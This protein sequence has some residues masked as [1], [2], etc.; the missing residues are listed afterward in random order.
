M[1]QAI[2]YRYARCLALPGL[3][4]VPYWHHLG[5]GEKDRRKSLCLSSRVFSSSRLPTACRERH[6]NGEPK[7][8]A[9]ALQGAMLPLREHP[10]MRSRRQLVVHHM[11]FA[12]DIA[13]LG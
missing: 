10:S 7:G 4:I 1:M 8:D 2:H 11:H 3:K 13:S 12:R 6:S 5:H 9:T